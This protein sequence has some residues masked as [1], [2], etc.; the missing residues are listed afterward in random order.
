MLSNPCQTVTR[1]AYGV[2]H[3]LLK[4]IDSRNAKLMKTVFVSYIR[5]ILEYCSPVWNPKLKQDIVILEKVQRRFTKKVFG[6]HDCTYSER[7]NILGLESLEFRRLKL[8]LIFMYKLI[9]GYFDINA[10]DFI[11][12]SDI[13][14]TRNSSALKLVQPKSRLELRHN[15]ITVRIIPLWNKISSNLDGVTSLKSFTNLL[16]T[17]QMVTL[18]SAHLAT[19]W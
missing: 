12:F 3:M 17:D 14:F 9:H 4:A 15:F 2:M 5:P 11:T 10:Q 16:E 6:L 8:D 18:I 13:K 19:Q 1:K 7:L